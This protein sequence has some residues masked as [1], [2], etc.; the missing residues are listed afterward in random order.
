MALIELTGVRNNTSDFNTAIQIQNSLG[1]VNGKF[2]RAFYVQ[3][4]G[5]FT[6]FNVNSVSDFGGGNI[7]INFTN[8]MPNDRYT[9]IVSSNHSRGTNDGNR[10]FFHVR[11]RQAGYVRVETIGGNGE[12]GTFYALDLAC[13]IF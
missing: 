2:C 4:P 3:G 11:D 5:F 8:T 9:T 7:Q 6:F 10:I 12:T 13:L 1:V